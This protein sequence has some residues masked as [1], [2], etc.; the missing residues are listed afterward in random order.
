MGVTYTATLI[1]V[2]KKSNQTE[3]NRD[4]T[5]WKQSILIIYMTGTNWFNFQCKFASI[6]WM[7]GA[8]FKLMDLP[9]HLSSW[10]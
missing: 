2:N 1:A 6:I 8:A 10:I 5:I 3:D 4:A 9:H 7:S